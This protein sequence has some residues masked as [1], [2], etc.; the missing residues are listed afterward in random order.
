MERVD[1]AHKN[2]APFSQLV[3]LLQ[4]CQE[5]TQ[6]TDEVV[7][8][9]KKGFELINEADTSHR[10]EV[11]KIS[12]MHV[13]ENGEVM[14][15]EDYLKLINVAQNLSHAIMLG[16]AGIRRAKT[17]TE[18]GALH[19]RVF[20]VFAAADKESAK[21]MDKAL[22]AFVESARG[23]GLGPQACRDLGAIVKT[24]EIRE[25]ILASCPSESPAPLPRP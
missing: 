15:N 7:E 9:L 5:N 17:S 8:L 13:L 12:A 23:K 3:K 1:E 24:P 25:A 18:V 21:S 20:E 4:L 10:F 14:T 11:E 19:Q 16:R 22:R 2:S 6:S